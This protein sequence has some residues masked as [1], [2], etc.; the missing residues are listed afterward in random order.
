MSP[1]WET[2]KLLD[3]QSHEEMTYNAQLTGL[4]RLTPINAFVTIVVSLITGCILWPVV[5][6]G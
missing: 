1:A 6:R 4:A 2:H 5:A 3:E